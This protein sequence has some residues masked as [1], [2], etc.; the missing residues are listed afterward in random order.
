MGGGG[1]EAKS[2]AFAV[3]RTAAKIGRKLL[4]NSVTVICHKW[5]KPNRR[6]GK[7]AEWRQEKMGREGEKED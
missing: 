4:Y 3:F 1:G 5:K 7:V 6:V 2:S